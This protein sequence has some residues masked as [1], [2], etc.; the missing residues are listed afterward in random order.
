MK[1]FYFVGGSDESKTEEFFQ[2]LTAAGVRRL[3]VIKSLSSGPLAGQVP[4]R[5]SS[6][7]TLEQKLPGYA[8]SGKW[9]W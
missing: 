6:P 3:K 5:S 1:L 2:R 4:M 7:G 9:T 8:A